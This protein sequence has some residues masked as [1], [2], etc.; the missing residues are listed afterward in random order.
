[1]AIGLNN[2]VFDVEIAE[3]PEAR[4]KGLSGRSELAENGG[5]LFKYQFD[6]YASYTM[7][8]TN[9][10]LDI[11]FFDKDQKF[12]AVYEAKAGQSKAVKP[13]FPYRYVVEILPGM[14]WTKVDSFTYEW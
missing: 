2:Q 10:D 3:T 4:I 14:D 8:N 9:F 7:S 13:G 5:M 6:T 11:A 1:M 12:I